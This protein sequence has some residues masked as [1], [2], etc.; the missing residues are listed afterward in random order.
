[1][2]KSAGNDEGPRSIFIKQDANNWSQEK[3]KKD[4]ER[5]DPRNGA[6]V[7]LFEGSIFIILLKNAYA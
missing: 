1:M 4:L 5:W 7:V 2:E 3:Q 6:A